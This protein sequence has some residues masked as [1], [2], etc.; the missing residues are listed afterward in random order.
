GVLLARLR[1]PGWQRAGRQDEYLELVAAS[2]GQAPRF[3]PF[4]FVAVQEASLQR[5]AD[6]MVPR[7]PRD[8][9]EPRVDGPH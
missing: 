6:A 2:R 9:T 8:A 5:I 4:D 7:K 1:G 3:S